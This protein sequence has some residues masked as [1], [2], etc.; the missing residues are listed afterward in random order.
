M[1][2]EN[3]PHGASEHTEVE[4]VHTIH[5]QVL[6]VSLEALELTLGLVRLHIAMGRPLVGVS[7]WLPTLARHTCF[8]A[9]LEPRNAAA[10][11]GT[12]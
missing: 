8:A 7:V 1:N 11:L 9:G 5:A 10:H 3:A 4:Q 6:S 12:L 2:R